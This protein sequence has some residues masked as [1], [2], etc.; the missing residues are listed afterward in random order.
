MLSPLWFVAALAWGALTPVQ[1]QEVTQEWVNQH[2]SKLTLKIDN[3]T[4]GTKAHRHALS[5]ISLR[6]PSCPM[7]QI[8]IKRAEGL[9]IPSEKDFSNGLSVGLSALYSVQ[10]GG[11]SFL[12]ADYTD[13][14]DDVLS[15]SDIYLKIGLQ[16]HLLFQGKG[17]RASAR[18]IGLGKDSPVFMEVDEYGGGS[19]C[20]KTLY[21]LKPDSIKAMPQDI[22]DHVL[23]L[24]PN[25]YVE[26]VLQLNVLLEGFT[27]YQDVD[28]D[29][30]LEILNGTRVDY[31]GDLKTKLKTTYGLTDNDLGCLSL[32]TISVYKWD[33]SK[34]TDLGDYYF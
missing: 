25:D 2:N 3:F 34:F 12:I 6:R 32:K 14:Y 5:L 4:Q 13:E 8:S 20:M 1:I 17:Y 28:H 24:D 23:N 15:S 22:Y 26:K 21:R 19:Q 7:K 29:G 27:L 30:S 11:A 16:Y 10:G 18:I 9:A 31:P 33:G